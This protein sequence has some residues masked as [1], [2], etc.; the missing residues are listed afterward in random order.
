MLFGWYKNIF[1]LLSENQQK[2]SQKLNNAKHH[3]Q[4][5][6]KKKKKPTQTRDVVEEGRVFFLGERGTRLGFFVVVVNIGDPQSIREE[7]W[8]EA[9]GWQSKSR[10]PE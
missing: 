1:L 3:S 4:K 9:G 2:I 8:D 10:K 7:G 6:P 5:F